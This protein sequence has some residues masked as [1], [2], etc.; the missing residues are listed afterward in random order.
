MILP[1]LI[2]SSLIY[3]RRLWRQ[4]LLWVII[5]VIFLLVHL[6][7]G[8]FIF[9]DNWRRCIERKGLFVIFIPFSKFTSNVDSPSPIRYTS[10][11]CNVEAQGELGCYFLALLSFF[12][13]VHISVVLYDWIDQVGVKRWLVLSYVRRALGRPTRDLDVII[14]GV[15]WWEKWIAFWFCARLAIEIDVEV[16]NTLEL[17]FC[18]HLEA[19]FDPVCRKL[20]HW[21]RPCFSTK[22]RITGGLPD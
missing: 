16:R 14:R 9:F 21:D 2:L 1:A 6:V 12:N 8:N 7:K 4:L 20:L 11:F 18:R 17:V 3:Y 5:D 19:A 13:E 10:G 22:G 15:C